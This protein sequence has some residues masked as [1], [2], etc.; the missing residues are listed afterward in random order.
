LIL[1]S[2]KILF[3]RHYRT[4]RSPELDGASI[5]LVNHEF[6]NFTLPFEN[7]YHQTNN[8]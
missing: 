4:T 2:Y 3:V 8:N 1:Y 6:T 7:A 5:F